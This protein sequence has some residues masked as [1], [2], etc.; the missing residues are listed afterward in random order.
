MSTEIRKT[1]LQK[2]AELN[3]STKAYVKSDNQLV[4]VK[5]FKSEIKHTNLTLIVT[6]LLSVGILAFGLYSVSK[7]EIS[8]SSIALIVFFTSSAIHRQII[9]IN[10]LKEQYFLAELLNISTTGSTSTEI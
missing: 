1:I 10:K 3:S 2:F 4:D 9:R 6:I 7:S 5:V 8:H